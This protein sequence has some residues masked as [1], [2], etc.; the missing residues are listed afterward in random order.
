MHL[1]Q[2]DP[3]ALL[4]LL[5]ARFSVPKRSA[6]NI[7]DIRS[8]CRWRISIPG[9]IVFLNVSI[10]LNQH[11]SLVVR[12]IQCVD[13][14]LL[15]CAAEC[16]DLSL[17]GLFTKQDCTNLHLWLSS[18]LPTTSN[19]YL[20]AARPR[21]SWRVR[22]HCTDLIRIEA[23]QPGLTSVY[24]HA[25]DVCLRCLRHL[26]VPCHQEELWELRTFSRSETHHV[27]QKSHCR[28]QL[29]AVDQGH[30]H[31]D[32]LPFTEHQLSSASA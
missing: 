2:L 27:L 1:C 10:R 13:P 11:D 30:P 8:S 26:S 19:L 31:G 28:A 12:R 23:Q 9:N 18:A 7:D 16:L 32:Q 3:S 5:G 20:T 6:V 21:L 4:R 25:S 24:V 14:F 22:L 29:A 15:G 17:C